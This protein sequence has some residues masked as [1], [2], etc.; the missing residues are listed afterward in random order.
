[1]FG[2]DMKLVLPLVSS[3]PTTPEAECTCP[4]AHGSWWQSLFLQLRLV[5]RCFEWMIGMTGMARKGN[6]RRR[7]RWLCSLYWA[8]ELTLDGPVA[9]RKQ[10]RFSSLLHLHKKPPYWAASLSSLSK[11]PV[12]LYEQLTAP[13]LAPDPAPT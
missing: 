13:L 4:G 11:V 8:F 5:L 9:L 12:P 7:I 1:M 3:T 10:S 2:G 6:G